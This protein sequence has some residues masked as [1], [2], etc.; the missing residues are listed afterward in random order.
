MSGRPR[1][2]AS[3]GWLTGSALI[4]RLI[5][6]G[7]GVLTARALGPE[8]KGTLALLLLA[9]LIS[10]VVIIGGLDLWAAR[11]VARGGSVHTVQSVL[12][13]HQ[14]LTAAA[15]A[16][17]TAILLLATELNK[18][19][20]G[21]TALLAW[22]ATASGLKLGL[23]LGVSRLR[24]YALSLLAGS[25]VYGSGVAA[26]VLF[27]QHTI[28]AFLLA[29][30]AGKL[31]TALWRVGSGP[32]GQRDPDLTY[33]SGL[34]FGAATMAGGLVTLALYRVDIALV[35][36]FSSTSDAGLYSVALALTEM[37]WI[38]PNSAA[39]AVIPRAA[40]AEPTVNTPLVC[41]VVV[42]AMAVI[43]LAISFIS[44]IA[45]P[46]VFGADFKSATMAVPA[47]ALGAV[48]IGVWKLLGHDLIARGDARTRLTTGLA[49]LGVMVTVDILFV[50]AFGILAASLGSLAAYT[51]AA[52]LTVR[53]WQRHYDV[54]IKDLL[55]VRRS[56]IQAIRRTASMRGNSDPPG[57]LTGGMLE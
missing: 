40:E 11:V 13:R 5:G 9:S 24:S 35:A 4:S 21:A 37:L 52:M 7:T 6:A 47:L 43:A 20:T 32:S 14:A 10:S 45:I 50:P 16:L 18:S 48:A 46:L 31:I 42:A 53:A 55:V 23:L 39:Q 33:R 30:V 34:E 15:V 28:G 44:P 25:G 22:A 8:G 26:L 19:L 57:P 54:P 56:D 29:A 2:R 36:S 51:M 49:G 41:R 3:V 12:R 1:L 27:G 17:A 38:L